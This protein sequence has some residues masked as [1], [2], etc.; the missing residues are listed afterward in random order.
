M[1][2][3][4]EIRKT[5]GYLRKL[6]DVEAYYKGLI[7]NPELNMKQRAIIEEIYIQ[8][9]LKLEHPELPKRDKR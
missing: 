4:A 9:K 5:F 2:I 6:E 8:R 7:E 3:Y 1:I